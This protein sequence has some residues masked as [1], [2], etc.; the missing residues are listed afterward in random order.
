M[1]FFRG[2]RGPE[3]KHLVETEVALLVD[4]GCAVADRPPR[5][6]TWQSKS[7]SGT[8]VMK[9]RG[10]FRSSLRFIT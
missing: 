7:K 6:P 5:W 3:W 1:A 2:L 8:D 4:V 10:L 9:E